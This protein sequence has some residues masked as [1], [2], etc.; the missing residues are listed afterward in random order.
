MGFS[1][2][3]G[4]WGDNWFSQL[5]PLNIWLSCSQL[6]HPCF[7]VICLSPTLNDVFFLLF[8]EVCQHLGIDKTQTSP[9][10]PQSDG[11]E[12]QHFNRT[13]EDMLSKFVHSHQWDWDCH[14][15]K[16]LMAYRSAVQKITG[17]TP[18]ELMLGRE[19]WLPVDLLFGVTGETIEEL[20]VPRICQGT[21]GAAG[22][23]ALVARKHLQVESERQKHP[24]DHRHRMVAYKPDDMV[25]HAAGA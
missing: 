7:P 5:P 19:V 10:H 13:L 8:E 9:L 15:P 4:F 24:Y 22:W 1:R 18:A 6:S 3:P 21:V 25:W 20:R 12:E 11:M 16:L 23:C 17:C 14:L 2:G